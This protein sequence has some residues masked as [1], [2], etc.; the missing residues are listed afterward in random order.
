MKHFVLLLGLLFCF[1]C[2]S[3]APRPEYDFAAEMSHVQELLWD[4]EIDCA[5]EYLE[6]LRWSKSSS[7]M[8]ERVRQD[9]RLK[10]GEREQVLVELQQWKQDLPHHPDLQ[11]LQ[12]RLLEDPIGRYQSLH[13]LNRQFP[14]H[15]WARLGLVSTAQVLGRW[16]SAEE[17]YVVA[18]ASEGS[19]VFQRIVQARLLANR[20]ETQAALDL[21]ENDAFAAQVEQS[22][23]EYLNLASNSGN[24]QEARRARAELDLRRVNQQQYTRANRIDLAFRRLIGEWPHIQNL[25]LR[26]ILRKLD[27][28]CHQ[29]GAPAGW[30]KV[31]RYNL[32]GLAQMVRPETDAGGVASEWAA[33]GRY[34][35]AGFAYGR[36]NELHL[37]RDV[38]VM[39]LEWPGHVNPIEMVTSRGVLS[40]QRGTAQGGTVFRG[41]YLRLDSMER[42]A[43]R[44]AASLK[45][46]ADIKPDFNTT[47]SDDLCANLPPMESLQLPT[48]LRLQ[49]IS[50]RP[51]HLRDFELI[52][53]TMHEAG[54]L[55]EI[56]SWLDEGLPLVSVGAQFLGSQ[57]KFGEPLL[58]LEYRAQ[59]RALAS[60]WNPKWAFAEI[61]ERG[62]QP[63]DPYYA[64]YRSLLRDLL[65]LAEHHDWP[66]LA[67]WDRQQPGEL[68]ALA[69]QLL[70]LKKLRPSPDAGTERLIQQ[71]VDFDLLENPPGDRIAPTQLDQ[72]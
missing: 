20:N 61:L 71:L 43:E 17:W 50:D 54:H 37:L 34:L 12:A 29:A 59:L 9:L 55:A 38:V 18:E 15:I 7:V 27:Q 2:A 21:L 47:P 25:E 65:T 31:P 19:G 22:L 39:R 14:Q 42:S 64:A 56:L 3:A 49:A 45:R 60:G 33:A 57:V 6:P 51:H 28:W 58:W 69:R 72:G 53:L 30:T 16:K 44:L 52:H 1:A 26:E 4:G 46:L 70:R 13:R 24:K 10:L 62:Q 68:V 67:Q 63:A 36:G 41:F 23:V 40:P 35:L 8:L 48:R 32:V 5:L 66:H 11:Y